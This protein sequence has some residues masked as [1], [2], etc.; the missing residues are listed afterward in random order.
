MEAGFRVIPVPGASAVVTALSAAGL[1]PSGFHFY[2][3]LPPQ[4]KA[5][6][7]VLSQLAGRQESFVLYEAPHRI[8]DVLK[9][10]AKVLRPERRVV[11]A[12]EI[13]KK[14]ET[15]TAVLCKDLDAWAKAHEPRGE[16]VILV[17]EEPSVA[18]DGL[19]EQ[20]QAW[21]LAIAKELPASK[22]AAVAAKVTGMKRDVIYQWLLAQKH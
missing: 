22:A 6:Q 18:Q 14:F 21:V 8:V 1:E 17:D 11:V 10:M 5:R 7:Q 4:T 13:T 20:D 12:R 19:S 15:F 16:Y 3:F 2:G 9:D